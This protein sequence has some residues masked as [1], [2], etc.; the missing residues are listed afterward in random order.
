MAIV[1]A[2]ESLVPTLTETA[3]ASSG[4]LSSSID[5]NRTFRVN[6]GV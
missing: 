6:T 2:V 4:P 5:S 3:F 1:D